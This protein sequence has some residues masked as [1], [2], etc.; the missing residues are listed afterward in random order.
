[1]ARVEFYQEGGRLI[2]AVNSESAVP[3]QGES[4]FFSGNEWRVVRVTWQV[5]SLAGEKRLRAGVEMKRKE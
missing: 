5:D 1:M 4:V 3:R 2:G